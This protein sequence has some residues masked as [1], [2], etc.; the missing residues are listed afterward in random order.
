MFKININLNKFEIKSKTLTRNFINQISWKAN[1]NV[2][3]GDL[4]P[5]LYLNDEEIKE[6]F[7]MRWGIKQYSNGD[8]VSF[9]RIETLNE[10]WQQFALKPC[11]IPI[12]GFYI[13][14]KDLNQTNYFYFCEQQKETIYVA[15]FYFIQE[16]YNKRQFH[17]LI[18]TQ[19]TDSN[20]DLF[21]YQHRMPVFLTKYEY[22]NWLQCDLK[23]QNVNKFVAIHKI[24]L[25]SMEIGNK[26][27]DSA[28]KE[29]KEILKNK[30]DCAYEAEFKAAAAEIDWEIAFKEY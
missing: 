21:A 20:E 4:V 7:C 3:K 24:K 6:L 30:E 23:T 13:R 18:A 11:V 22:K 8:H 14:N 1:P 5:V 19:S 26:I 25:K 9:A 28:I 17:C 12:K 15:A 16:S 29:E 27:E 10:K 2:A